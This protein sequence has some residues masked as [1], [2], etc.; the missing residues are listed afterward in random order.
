[1]EGIWRIEVAQNPN[2]IAAVKTHPQASYKYMI[3]VLD[4]LHDLPGVVRGRPPGADQRFLRLVVD[5]ADRAIPRVTECL[6]GRGVALE[7]VHEERPAF[8]DVFVRLIE[9][10]AR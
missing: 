5:H 3:D 2:L 7:S 6:E 10:G 8:D 1:M 4:A 9:D